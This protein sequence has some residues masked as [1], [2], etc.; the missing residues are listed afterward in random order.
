MVS[1]SK[2]NNGE[3]VAAGPN[4]TRQVSKRERYG[5]TMVDDR[6]AFEW[7]KKEKLCIDHTYQRNSVS[8]ARVHA[9][10][11]SWSWVACG[12]LLVGMRKNGSLWVV[13]GQHRKLA[14][15]KRD[16]IKELPCM[17]FEG[18][19]ASEAAG[20]LRSNENRKPL[21]GLDKLNALVTTGDQVC[22]RI[23]AVLERY[24]Y[25]LCTGDNP[26]YIQCVG[27]LRKLFT[28]D[29][30]LSERVFGLAV[31]IADG[32]RITQY[33]LRGMFALEL[34][35]RSENVGQSIFDKH[36][37]DTLKR[38]GLDKLNRQIANMSAVEGVRS[39]KAC[40]KAIQHELNRGRSSRRI[41]CFD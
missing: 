28:K 36:N 33:P 12:S 8:L 9:L 21:T 30:D 17:I 4:S 27:E 15:D 41:T 39:E 5:W 34:K 1:V 16:D 19:P 37:V 23:V 40:A 11:S 22:I 32:E 20:F 31:S 10:A 3:H 13:D 6:G 7:I 18:E 14:A 29:G 38:I 35:M 26:R 25:K 2:I 24:G